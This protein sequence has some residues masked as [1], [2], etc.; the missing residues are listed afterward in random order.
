[1][2]EI[3]QAAA[4]IAL[5][6]QAR[7][8]LERA[9]SL[10][11]GR[12]ASEVNPVDVLRA[13]LASSSRATDA[14]KA[15]GRDPRAI[16]ALLPGADGQAVLPLRQL[17]VNANRE[18]QVLGH[19]Q[20][21]PIHILLALMYSDTPA[22]SAALQKA[23][24]T[25]YDLRNHVQ[26]GAVP[27]D[28]GRPAA[29]SR[30]DA[31]LRRRPLPSLRGVLGISPIFLGLVAMTVVSGAVLWLNVVPAA[32]ALIT[33]VFVTS[34]WVTSLCLHEF[35]HAFVAYLGGDRSVVA[36]GY[37][38]LNPLLYANL[39][40]TIILPVIFLLLGGIALPGGARSEE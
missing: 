21:D 27:A 1:M 6:R 18:A 36:A 7:E 39:L 15:L 3:E 26:M 25:L 30:P 34:A 32:A 31:G 33:I 38:T 17:L 14:L 20:V 2:Q 24:L 13:T 28:A 4:D 35:G 5:T 40:M 12:G 37:L 16:D 23:G 9:A 29:R 22:T 19:Y 10:A 11:S 8:V